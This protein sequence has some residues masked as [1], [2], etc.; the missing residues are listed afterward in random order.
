MTEA[1]S[2]SDPDTA[3][4]ATVCANC[5]Q[6]RSDRFC[7]KCGQNDRDYIRSLPPLLGDILKETFEINS[8][9]ANTL[10]PMFFKPGEL[11]CEFS[12]NRRASYIPPIR[13]YLFASIVFFF[14]LPL[15]ANL[16]ARPEA[17]IDAAERDEERAE[18]Q[19]ASEDVD[20]DAF[21]ALLPAE[22]RRKVDR[23]LAR[24]EGFYVP[25]AALYALARAVE[26]AEMDVESSWNRYLLAR[27]VDAL[28]DL[29]AG[30]SLLL[31]NLPFAM[32]V[33]LPA[34]A[35]L[36]MLFFWGSRR[37]YTE[38]LVFAVHLH[39]FAFI[40][41][42]LLM[43]LP[44]GDDP[45]PQEAPKRPPLAEVVRE[46]AAP[47]AEGSGDA[48]NVSRRERLLRM[49]Q[50]AE[51]GGNDGNGGWLHEALDWVSLLLW[52]WVPAYHYLALRRYYR[53]GRFKTACKWAMLSF[54]YG[55]LLIPG[56]LLSVLVTVLQL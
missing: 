19:K 4:T 43:A 54:A 35:L 23:I 13:L 30:F 17:K 39:S 29:K 27:A 42:T 25:K 3:P 36:L 15:I 40:V 32:F 8:R 28:E 46:I 56:F 2:A 1:S 53:N 16:G 20:M 22:Q 34:Y 9:I 14:L 47:N 49:R 10:K 48:E 50:Q 51:A 12:R 5:G 21:K 41:F 33:T 6:R 38:H 7:P 45:R 18:L 37:Y 31:D 11:A 52:L 26:E 24:E 44:D 55:I